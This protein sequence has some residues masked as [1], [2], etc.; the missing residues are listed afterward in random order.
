MEDMLFEGRL[1]PIDSFLINVHSEV[2][3]TRV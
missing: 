1:N 2:Y 3:R